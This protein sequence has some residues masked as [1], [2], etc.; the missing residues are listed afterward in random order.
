MTGV[1][2]CAL[3]IYAELELNEYQIKVQEALGVYSTELQQKNAE[4]APMINLLQELRKEYQ[5]I[6]RL[7]R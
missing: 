3:P 2:T 5:E 4:I 6:T 7:Y 1:Q